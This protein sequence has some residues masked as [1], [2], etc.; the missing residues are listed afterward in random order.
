MDF[1]CNA[2]NVV[3]HFSSFFCY[4]LVVSSE[5]P[6]LLG[7][8]FGW[9]FLFVS[10][11][12]FVCCILYVEIKHQVHVWNLLFCFSSPPGTHTW[13]PLLTTGTAGLLEGCLSVTA[14]PHLGK[15]LRRDWGR[16]AGSTEERTGLHGLAA[17]GILTTEGSLSFM[18]CCYAIWRN[19]T[20]R[21]RLRSEKLAW[22]QREWERE[23]MGRL[24][25]MIKFKEEVVTLQSKLTVTWFVY[26]RAQSCHFRGCKS[27]A[28]LELHPEHPGV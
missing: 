10:W 6:N 2:V 15:K 27:T 26:R 12:S 1:L 19:N 8:F 11:L 22:G 20:S 18:G 4:I 24:I 17:G 9:V 28:C 7:F 13:G 25:L 23:R 14:T 16:I 5:K 3:T 21:K